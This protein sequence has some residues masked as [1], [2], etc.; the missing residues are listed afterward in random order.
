MKQMELQKAKEEQDRAL[1][2]VQDNKCEP[3]K[4][5]SKLLKHYQQD[6]FQEPLPFKSREPIVLADKTNV[7]NDV[8]EVQTPKLGLQKE[9]SFNQEGYNAFTNKAAKKNKYKD[10]EN[11]KVSEQAHNASTGTKHAHVSVGM[12]R[13]SSIRWINFC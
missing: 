12:K 11:C 13:H 3:P 8:I 5:S 6:N 4:K 2:M 9:F 7:Y 10:Q 1:K